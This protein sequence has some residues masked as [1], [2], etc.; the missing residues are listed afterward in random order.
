ML[1]MCY[2]CE[3]TLSCTLLQTNTARCSS[4]VTVSY[5]SEWPTR[6]PIAKLRLAHASV[7]DYLTQPN[8][9]GPAKFHIS[10]V[11]ARQVSI[12]ISV[13]SLIH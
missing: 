10:P 5:V 3:Y 9:A 13:P 12:T 7:A 6:E 8:P 2:L 4:L 11:S 1:E